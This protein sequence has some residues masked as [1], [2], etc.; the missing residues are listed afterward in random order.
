M[1]DFEVSFRGRVRGPISDGRMQRWAEQYS[2]DVASAIADS[3]KDVW[4]HN[5][6]SRLRHQ[7]PYYTTRI[8]KR[9]LSPTRYEIHDSGVVYGHW[10]E[11]TGSRNAPVT[12][13]PGYWSLRDAKADMK[14]KRGNIARRIL[15]RYRSQGKLI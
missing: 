12:R 3:S 11:G 9:E 13:F 15:R 4:L 1:P 2:E 14:T 5:L 10:L 8:R 7:T 6:D